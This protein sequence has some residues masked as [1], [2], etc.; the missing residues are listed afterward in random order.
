VF[1]CQSLEKLRV[2]SSKLFGLPDKEGDES[3]IKPGNTGQYSEEETHGFGT[4]GRASTSTIAI[5]L[6]GAKG[7]M[8]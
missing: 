1:E 4:P 2:C 6:S 8:N 3:D 5:A 7:Q